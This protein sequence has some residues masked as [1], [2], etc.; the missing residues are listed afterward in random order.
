MVQDFLTEIYPQE[1]KVLASMCC[2]KQL[3]PHFSPVITKAKFLSQSCFTGCDKVMTRSGRFVVNVSTGVIFLYYLLW[4]SVCATII[5]CM[6]LG[7][8]VVLFFMFTFHLFLCDESTFINVSL[9]PS[10]HSQFFCDQAASFCD[11][12]NTSFVIL[13]LHVCLQL[14]QW[15]Y[16]GDDQGFLVGCDAWP[17]TWLLL[18]QKFLCRPNCRQCGDN[19]FT[20]TVC[21]SFLFSVFVC[22][23]NSIKVHISPLYS[24]GTVFHG[25]NVLFTS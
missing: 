5:I 16:H 20:S 11:R 21:D 1:Q 2:S 19:P 7:A 8:W 23:F 22:F 13:K 12:V 17:K 24:F 25:E 4:A 9:A 10:N 3:F 14:Y 15:V 18:M 6:A